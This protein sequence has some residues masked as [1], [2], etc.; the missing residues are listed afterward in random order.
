MGPRGP[1]PAALPHHRSPP[2]LLCLQL[3]LHLQTLGTKLLCDTFILSI[4]LE[5]LRLA[6][7]KSQ[8]R[9]GG[10]AGAAA[11]PAG[12]VYLT[13]EAFQL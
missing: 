1:H 7:L 8:V 3:P 6:H 9:R 4:T 13:A 11:K 5:E 10:V 2:L 12:R